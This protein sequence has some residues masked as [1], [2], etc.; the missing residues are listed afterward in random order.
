MKITHIKI[1]YWKL[2]KDT[3]LKNLDDKFIR[4]LAETLL[5]NLSFK[6]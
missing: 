3:E 6:K 4:N 2:F 1:D 5:D